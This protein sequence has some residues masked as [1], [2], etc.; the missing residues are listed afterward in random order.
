[1]K[2]GHGFV[3]IEV[4]LEVQLFTSVQPLESS[5]LT[6]LVN[7][8]DLVLELT[9]VSDLVGHQSNHHVR[10]VVVVLQSLLQNY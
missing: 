3:V 6:L 9:Q 8:F 4:W 5:W 7:D 10:V 2:S 1:M